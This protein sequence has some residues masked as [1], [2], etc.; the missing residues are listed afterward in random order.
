MNSFATHTLASVL[1]RVAGADLTSRR[2]EQR[3][4]PHAEPGVDDA[5]RE[6]DDLR[7]QTGDLVDHD[8][9]GTSPAR[10]HRTREAVVRERRLGE[11]GKLDRHG[12]E[13]YGLPIP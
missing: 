13:H 9:R 2:A 7:V 3:R 12:V 5:L 4:H 8:H 11:A 10:V 1:D 6:L